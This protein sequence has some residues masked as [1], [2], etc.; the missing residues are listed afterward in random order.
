MFISKVAF[1][2]KK[3]RS[4]AGIPA[5]VAFLNEGAE[6]K[7]TRAAKSRAGWWGM[8]GWIG[9]GGRYRT[10]TYDLRDVNATL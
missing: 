4:T 6:N 8:E 5:L 1:C 2:L 9:G 3:L 10:R 7:K